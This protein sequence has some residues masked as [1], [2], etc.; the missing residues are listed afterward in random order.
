MRG[1]WGGVAGRGRIDEGDSAR[2][3]LRASTHIGPYRADCALHCA[4][5]CPLHCASRA[6][7]HAAMVSHS[8][9]ACVAVRASRCEVRQHQLSQGDFPN[10]RRLAEQ[11]L[12][13][14]FTQFYKPSTERSKKL[15]LLNV[16]PAAV[17]PTS[18]CMQP[19]S[20]CMQPVP[21]A[22]SGPCSQRPVPSA[23]HAASTPSPD[24]CVRCPPSASPAR[25][26]LSVAA[27]VVARP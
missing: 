25:T 19:T 22:A 20:R 3:S 9:R 10:W 7:A 13:A 16:T 1:G 27:K 17:Q 21:R 2:W 11:L 4:A 23:P 26:S 5:D 14:D 18:L 6:A 15:K 8:P 24:H 12:N